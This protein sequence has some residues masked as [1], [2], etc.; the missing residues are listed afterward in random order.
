M[1]I[2]KTEN[3]IFLRDVESN[4]IQEAFII[5]KE[6][7]K[8]EEKKNS[9]QKTSK[10]EICILKEAENLINCEIND[11]NLKY[12]KFKVSKLERKL[13]IQKVFNIF[14]IIALLSSIIIK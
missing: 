3:V 6:N 2:S 8:F 14:C 13:K 4:I 9:N 7:V 5:L 11:C 10:N 1:Q 12:D